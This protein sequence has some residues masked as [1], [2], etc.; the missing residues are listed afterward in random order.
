MVTDDLMLMPEVDYTSFGG[1]RGDGD[2]IGGTIR[3]QRSF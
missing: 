1:E 3:L 2:A